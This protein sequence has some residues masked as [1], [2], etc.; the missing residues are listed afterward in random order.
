MKTD[1]LIT[2]NFEKALKHAENKA[3]FDLDNQW[4]V[5]IRYG[6]FGA[7]PLSF[8]EGRDYAIVCITIY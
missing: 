4:C 7:F 3:I 6:A 1:N 2:M 5:A 8:A